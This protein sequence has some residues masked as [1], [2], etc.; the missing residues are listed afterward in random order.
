MWVRDSCPD[1][2]RVDFWVEENG[3]IT[4][5]IGGFQFVDR[6]QT[7]ES[8]GAGKAVDVDRSGFRPRVQDCGRLAEDQD[9]GEPGRRKRMGEF[10]HNCRTRPPKRRAK[11]GQDLVWRAVDQIRAPAE[12]GRGWSKTTTPL[13]LDLSDSYSHFCALNLNQNGVIH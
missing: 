4:E 6:F 9:A 5:Q 1:V 7:L 10:V 13:Q 3:N 2:G 8:R 11:R 12:V